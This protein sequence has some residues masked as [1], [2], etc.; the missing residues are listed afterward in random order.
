[1]RDSRIWYLLEENT[2][3]RNSSGALHL[4][5]EPNHG[6]SE[7]E[8]FWTPGGLEWFREGVSF[9]KT[10]LLFSFS[11]LQECKM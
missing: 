2:T 5:C 6:P 8:L 4:L 10:K 3:V 11:C 9:S 7:F 1:M